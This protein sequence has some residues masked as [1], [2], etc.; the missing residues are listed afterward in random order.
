MDFN[1]SIPKQYY[2]TSQ[3]NFPHGIKIQEKV[4]SPTISPTQGKMRYTN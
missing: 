2:Q 1:R 4:D 3:T